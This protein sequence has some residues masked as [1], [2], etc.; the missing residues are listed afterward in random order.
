MLVSG[1]VHRKGKMVSSIA[2]VAS[3]APRGTSAKKYLLGSRRRP[4]E[5]QNTSLREKKRRN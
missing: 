5:T 3:E 1:Y 4:N 2:D